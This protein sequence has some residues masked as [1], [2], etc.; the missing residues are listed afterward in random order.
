MTSTAEQVL[1]TIVNKFAGNCRHCGQTVPAGGG[2]AVKL[3]EGWRTQHTTCPTAGREQVA[4]PKSAQIDFTPTAEQTA[5]ITAFATGADLVIQA[6]AGAGKTATLRLIAAQALANNRRGVYT[7]F[8]KAIVTDT[9]RTMPGNISCSTMHALAYAAIGHQYK[10]RLNAP[11]QR[12]DQIAMIL[13]IDP[14]GVPFGKETKTLA[15]GFL[16]GRVMGAVRRF[17]QS[18]DSEITARHFERIEGLDLPDTNGNPTYTINDRLASH[19]VPFARKAWADLTA[20]I[21]RLRFTHDCY[22]RMWEMGSP[23][24]NADFILGDEMQDAD[25]VMA[26]IIEQQRQ[27][28]TQIVV[29]GDEM[30]AIYSFRGA[31]DALARF[32]A[33]GA[34]VRFLTQSF[35]FGDAV[36]EQ[37][38]GLLERLNARLRVRG[39]GSMASVVGPIERP[40]CIL[41]RTNAG[42]IRNLLTAIGDGRRV[43]LVGSGDDIIRFCEAALD[44]QNGRLTGHPEL[45]CFADWMA[46]RLYVAEDESGSDLKLMVQLIEDFGA[47]TI[48]A[49]LR[50]QPK[51]LRP[52]DL[53]ISTAHKAKGREWDSVQIGAD[54]RAPKGDEDLSPEE[55]RLAY[56]AVTRARRQLDL[57]AV[58]HLQAGWTPDD[59]GLGADPEPSPDDPAPVASESLRAP[60]IAA[61]PVA[62]AV[63]DPSGLHT[64]TLGK[65]TY[66][67]RFVGRCDCGEIARLTIPAD[68]PI[69]KGWVKWPPGWTCKCGRAVALRAVAGQLTEGRCDPRCWNAYGDDCHCSCGGRFHGDGIGPVAS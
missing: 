45:V 29:V 11:R 30:Q 17:C 42:A 28:G 52:G 62:V 57:T 2:Q 1:R 55:L 60:E 27:Y 66:Y 34:E 4:Q 32:E 50:R 33:M 31:V 68:A 43:I 22:L 36:A 64:V 25:P 14:Y 40:D 35:R 69:K 51:E 54:F 18:C 46:V 44:L 8:N 13:G 3:A 23:R 49:A 16:A 58:P 56:V 9:A 26:S 41:T 39:F 65:V 7:A 53:T 15:A 24:I 19:L 10:D 6:G 48:I 67:S 20:P 21:G 38:N 5:C 47:E 59:D 61:E 37:A 63:P 12:P